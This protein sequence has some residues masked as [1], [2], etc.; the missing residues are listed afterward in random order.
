MSLSIVVTCSAQALFEYDHRLAFD[1]QTEPMDSRTGVSVKRGS[2]QVIKDRRMEFILVEPDAPPKGKTLRPAIVMQHGGGQQMATYI[3]EATMLAK[4]GAVCM[5]TE[6]PYQRTDQERK[7]TLK[8]AAQRDSAAHIVI[9]ER[10]SFDWLQSR[11]DV[12]RSRLAYVGHS[13]GGNAGA[14][15]AYVDKRVKAFV[16]LGLVARFTSHVQEN[17]AWKPY[18]E[19]LTQQELADT[20]ALARAI[21]PDQFLPQSSPATILFQCARFDMDDVKRGCETAY[22]LAGQP[23]KLIWYDVD[24][25]FANVEASLD[26]LSWLGDR[27][28]LTEVRNILKHQ[29]PK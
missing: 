14:I 28:N 8:G 21:D 11:P 23:K 29:V 24:H 6:A 25:G 15:L 19:S 12:D 18:R 20:L 27:L 22:E 26:R 9:S 2:L 1:V 5:I 3:S 13:Y 16:L 17:L 4:A 7:E 10:R